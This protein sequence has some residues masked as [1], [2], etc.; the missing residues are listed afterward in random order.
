MMADQHKSLGRAGLDKVMKQGIQ[1]GFVVPE[2]QLHIRIKVGAE[3]EIADVHNCCSEHPHDP[4]Q[5][6]QRG[7]IKLRGRGD[8]WYGGVGL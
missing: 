7:N 6:L 4:Q 8:T 3:A 5:R 1:S 2:I